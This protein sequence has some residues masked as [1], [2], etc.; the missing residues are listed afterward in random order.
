MK[1]RHSGSL[2]RLA[3]LVG[4]ACSAPGGPARA[5]A[6]VFDD[7]FWRQWGDGQSELAGYDLTFSR[8]GTVRQGTAVVIFVTARDEQSDRVVGLELGAADDETK[9]LHFQML[10]SKIERLLEKKAES[11]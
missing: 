8:Y 3:A 6:P 4:L 5:A 11:A 10:L 7:A 2:F 1:N 9:P